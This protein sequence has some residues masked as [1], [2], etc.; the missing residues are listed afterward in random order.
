MVE[1]SDRE[2]AWDQAKKVR[3]K[4]PNL[5]RRDEL[6]NEI[7]K[8]AMAPPARKAGKSTIETPSPKEGPIIVGTSG[9]SEP[10]QTAERATSSST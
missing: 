2:W 9:F 1:K 7:Y 8:P 3:G 5:Y 4:N 10:T 6:G